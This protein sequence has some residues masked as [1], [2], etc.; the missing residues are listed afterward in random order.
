MITPSNVPYTALISWPYYNFLL[1]SLLHI[2]LSW[3]DGSISHIMSTMI[4]LNMIYPGCS[5]CCQLPCRNA[6][7]MFTVI[8]FFLSI[9]SVDHDPIR[10]YND[11]VGK[12]DSSF[13]LHS[14]CGCPSVHPLSF[15]FLLRFL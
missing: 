15:I 11:T 8:T 13:V 10:A 9:T 4:L 1:P 6:P 7:G 2:T 5:S 12:L 3:Y 14:C